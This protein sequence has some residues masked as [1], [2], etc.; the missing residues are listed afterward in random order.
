MGPWLETLTYCNQEGNYL[1]GWGLAQEEGQEEADE[2]YG[3][4][5]SDSRDS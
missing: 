4:K 5:D 3:T 2:N 1:G